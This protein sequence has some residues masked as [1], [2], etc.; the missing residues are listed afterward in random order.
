MVPLDSSHSVLRQFGRRRFSCPR[1]LDCSERLRSAARWLACV[2]LAHQKFRSPIALTAVGGGGGTRLRVRLGRHPG[3]VIHNTLAEAKAPSLLHQGSPDA[4]TA[5][6]LH[7]APAGCET[8]RVAVRNACS[9]L[10]PHLRSLVRVA[11]ILIVAATYGVGGIQGAIAAGKESQLRRAVVPVEVRYPLE[12]HEGLPVL[13]KLRPPLLDEGHLE[14]AS[15]EGVLGRESDLLHLPPQ[16]LAE[17]DVKVLELGVAAPHRPPMLLLLPHGFRRRQHRANDLV[18]YERPWRLPIDAT[19]ANCA[20]KAQPRGSAAAGA[21]PR[22]RL[23]CC[24]APLSAELGH[25][26]EPERLPEHAVVVQELHHADMRQV[27]AIC[28][29]DGD[30]DVSDAHPSVFLNLAW[31]MG[32]TTTTTT[33]KQHKEEKQK[34][35]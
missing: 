34:K 10:P 8:P 13:V 15:G 4:S 18:L 19:P 7:A 6:C 3:S 31:A 22:R 33:T 28:V 17:T 9:L 30:K 23:G 12:A 26:D 5:L 20:P 29:I 16:E 14:F 32:N 24:T 35:L 11:P 27:G 2:L 1:K 25:A 21:E